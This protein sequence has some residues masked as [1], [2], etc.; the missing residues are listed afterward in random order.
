[1]PSILLERNIAATAGL[2]V[3]TSVWEMNSFWCE[4]SFSF[5]S[6]QTNDP[7]H[8]KFSSSTGKCKN[9]DSLFLFTDFCFMS[10]AHHTLHQQEQSC[11]TS[12]IR[13]TGYASPYRLP[14]CYAELWRFFLILQMMTYSRQ[15]N[16][17]IVNFTHFLTFWRYGWLEI[18]QRLLK[19][20]NVRIIN[21]QNNQGKTPLH[22]ACHE[23]HEKI[24]K[25]LLMEGA[26]I[27]R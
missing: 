18:A 22:L 8:W 24:A 9:T 3:E 10:K 21:V 27:E 7:H 12:H 1:M 5:T 19:K 11:W 16:V 4:S 13:F 20:R 26:T 14:V 17:F 15:L 23:G 6:V 2:L 25:L